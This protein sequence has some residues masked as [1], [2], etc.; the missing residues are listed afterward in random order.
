M[1]ETLFKAATLISIMS[2][3][4]AFRPISGISL[5]YTLVISYAYTLQAVGLFCAVSFGYISA[6]GT[7]DTQ[8]L[9]VVC[10]T[11]MNL[12]S[13][14]NGIYLALEK[15]PIYWQWMVYISPVYWASVATL[16]VNLEGYVTPAHC[17]QLPGLM[18]RVTC[19]MYS[20][21][22]A[23]LAEYKY[24]DARVEVSLVVLLA[25][26]LAGSVL[27]WLCLELHGGP[28][29]LGVKL[30]N[31]ARSSIILRTWRHHRLW[32]RTVAMPPAKK[33][34]AMQNA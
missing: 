32:V 4:L 3:T 19:G 1:C 26:W 24:T 6:T 9:V 20:S 14:F 2:L 27:A 21:G 28:H 11:A 25:I 8:S 10:A 7:A 31:G 23:F 34:P 17:D 15:T 5:V 18:E 22:D 12:G 29:S 33:T 30:Q 13:F 16:R